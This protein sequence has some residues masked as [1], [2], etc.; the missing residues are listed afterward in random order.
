MA[1]I[2]RIPKGSP[3][4]AGE[5][6]ANLTILE[7][8]SGSFTALMTG[9]FLAVSS[10]VANLSTLQGTLSGQFTGS[11]LISGSLKFTS[12][13][14]SYKN[15]TDKVV[16]YDP[17]DGA[18]GWSLVSG[19]IQTSGTS[20]TSAT[21][22]TSG[23]NG[24]SGT[25]GT[26]GTT[27]TAGTAGTSG[28][29]GTDGSAG[30]SGV[31]GT[32]GQDGT[33][34]GADLVP[35]I[36]QATASLQQATASLNIFTGSLSRFY[37]TT[38]SIHIFTAST[39]LSILGVS[40]FTSSQSN[41]NL[42]IARVT[43]S[44]NFATSSLNV[45]TGALN[46]FTG[47]I[48]GEVNGLEAYTASLKA[49]GLVS[50]AA[51]ITA[52]GFGAG[53]GGSSFPYT[54]SAIISGSFQLTGSQFQIGAINA[55]GIVSGAAGLSTTGPLTASLRE[56]YVW[57]GGDT[58]QNTRQI[59]TSSLSGGG[60]GS[61][62]VVRGVNTYTSVSTLTFTSNF[63]VTNLGS[64]NI[65]FDVVGGGGGSGTSG[66]SGTS[67]L[68]GTSGSSG[69]G[70]SGTSGSSGSS[71]AGT[72]GTSG[73]SAIGSSGTSGSPG[74]SGTSGSSGTSGGSNGSAGSSGTSGITTQL[75][76]RDGAGITTVYGVSDISFSGSIILTPS[77]SNGVIVTLTDGNASGFSSASY[78]GWITGSAQILD[79]GFVQS[80]SGI[81]KDFIVTQSMV[82]DWSVT[83]TG[84]TA[85]V[86]TPSN[87]PTLERG[88]D[89]DIWIYQ[90]DTIVFNVNAASHPLWIKT[91][92][93][94]GT[95]NGVSGVNNNGASSGTITWNTTGSL[96]GTY[97]YQCQN[98]AAMVGT[99]YVKDRQRR[100]QFKDGRIVHSGSMWV[101]GGMIVTG[102]IY[103]SGSL[104]QNGV[105]FQG[106]GGGGPFAQTG[107]Y[108]SANGDVFVTGSFRVSGSIT[109]SAITVTSPGTPEIYSATNINLNA[110]NAV[111]ITSS[112]LRLASF[113]D[114]QTS[115]LA[116]AN[117]DIYYN[118][119]TNKFMGRISGSWI[120]FTSGSSVGGAGGGTSGTSG[121]SGLL[122]LTGATANGLVRYDGSGANASVLSSLT[123]SG[124]SL[125]VTSSLHVSSL[126]KIAPSN[127]LP[128]TPEAGTF[129]V[130]GSGA[131]YKPY[132]Y[133]GSAWNALY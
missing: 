65:S 53:G 35:R 13:S 26:N 37:Q 127:P 19:S 61:L 97:Y 38:A 124:T 126:V 52:L 14:I 122:S 67:G 107:S 109:A 17:A 43:G 131:V 84:N 130:S 11:A 116:P 99:I 18:L 78:N 24:T 58:N 20:G 77:G 75:G 3:L 36:Q 71:L 105:A 85:Y 79:A 80:S 104:Y 101:D 39:D 60:G 2:K 120:D 112:S 125:Q 47:S 63:S 42:N 6:D 7:E 98:H 4:T 115:S 48:R 30:T 133:D 111:V 8:T 45:T 103:F 81:F 106:G 23:V 34:A 40:I 57:V 68:P 113:S 32:S 90:G 93:T 70:S 46:T 28:I 62:S 33:L 96:P 56:G 82:R 114:G 9:S 15:T 110:G 102:S 55:S 83:N 21:S 29:S 88:E 123:F 22:G 66:T 69:N 76:I 100:T 50:G 72:D 92:P 25:S 129:A 95:G 49:V 54:G 64:G 91:S 41:V 86:L 89:V 108:Y 73:T 10:S 117:G 1:I 118:T 16:V 87:D 74:V 51:Q 31:S 132:F 119:T 44:L 27:G 5:M 121:T 12:A 94:I 59:A 128:A